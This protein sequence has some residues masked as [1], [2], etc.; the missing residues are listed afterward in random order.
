[1]KPHYLAVFR[2][3]EQILDA[4]VVS[5]GIDSISQTLINSLNWDKLIR[6]R[7]LN[8]QVLFSELGKLEFIHPVFNHLPVGSCPMFYTAYS[9]KRHEILEHLSK[10]GIYCPV[11]WPKPEEVVLAKY[12]NDVL[13]IYNSIFSIPCDQRYNVVDMKR[14]VRILLDF[15]S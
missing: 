12:N 10:H 13:Q 11:H 15:G 5:I 7:R 14:I 4:H 2:E 6:K 3:C 9:T 8:Y 1:M